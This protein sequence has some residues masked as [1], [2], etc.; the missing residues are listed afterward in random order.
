MK[1]RQLQ[2]LR[3]EAL[4]GK[5]SVAVHE[6]AEDSLVGPVSVTPLLGADAPDVVFVNGKVLTVDEDF[7]TVEAVA[8]TVDVPAA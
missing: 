7:S 2:C 8:V 5:R 1:A 3:D 4:T 6:D